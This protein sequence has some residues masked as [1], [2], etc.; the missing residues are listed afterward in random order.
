M[1]IKY[2]CSPEIPTHNEVTYNEIAQEFKKYYHTVFEYNLRMQIANSSH[3]QPHDKSLKFI[4][5]F[6]S[7]HIPTT[8]QNLF[9][10]IP[11]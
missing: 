9:Q 11:P 7:K 5:K 4:H 8:H 2:D 3:E 1:L 6:I 10:L